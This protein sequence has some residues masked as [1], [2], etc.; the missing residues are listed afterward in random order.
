MPSRRDQTA[1]LIATTLGKLGLS[2][3]DWH[4]D[5]DVG[6]PVGRSSSRSWVGVEITHLPS[7][8]TSAKSARGA[9]TKQQARLEAMNMISELLAEASGRRNVSP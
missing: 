8:R 7:G 5:V 1:E 9:F 3:D 2:E 4:V 6:K